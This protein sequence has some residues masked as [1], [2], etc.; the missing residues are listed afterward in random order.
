[1]N[2]AIW[3]EAFKRT[4]K[5]WSK[6]HPE[7]VDLFRD[8]LQL[9]LRDPFHPSLRTHSLSGI[10]KGLWAARINYEYRLI[11]RFVGKSKKGILLIDIGAHDEVY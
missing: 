6:R 4:Y 10:L 1:M 2:E 3:D 11:F 9:L 8:R 5:N 7:S